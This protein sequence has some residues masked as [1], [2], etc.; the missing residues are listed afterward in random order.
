[1]KIMPDTDLR[2]LAAPR[3]FVVVRQPVKLGTPPKQL[4]SVWLAPRQK[5]KKMVEKREFSRGF[6]PDNAEFVETVKSLFGRHQ[7]L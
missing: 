5:V 1:M 7:G 2:G 4:C 3:M 6:G